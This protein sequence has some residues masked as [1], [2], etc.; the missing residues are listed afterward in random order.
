MF[1]I[2]KKE[3]VSYFSSLIAYITLGIFL[4]VLGLFV[5]V[6]NETSILNY[7]F[8][9]LNQ[10]FLITPIVFTFLIPAITMRSFSEEKQNGTIEF[11]QTKPLTDFQIVFAK[12]LAAL[13]LVMIALLPTLIYVYSVYMLGSPK[14]NL[15]IGGTIGSYVGL[16]FLVAVFVSIGMFSS[17]ITNNQIVAFVLGTFLC[18]FI[19]WIFYYI[20]K[21]P[22][23]VGGLDDAIEKMGI[24]YHFESISRGV[25]D[26]RNVVYFLSLIVFFLF[27]SLSALKINRS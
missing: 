3:L 12:Y 26:T 24:A 20:S 4:L 6:F 18:F 8:A 19:Y 5:W 2:Y 25:I 23:F 13:S 7:N 21:M 9:G 17:T 11:L 27:A 16:V 22:V 15:D 14:G 10:L 1:S